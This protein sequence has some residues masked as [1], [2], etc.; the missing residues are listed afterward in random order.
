MPMKNMIQLAVCG[1]VCVCVCVCV[2][3]CVCVCVC[4]CMRAC[5]ACVFMRACA[6]MHMHASTCKGYCPSSKLRAGQHARWRSCGSQRA[7]SSRSPY[8][9][10]TCV[11]DVLFV[12]I[13]CALVSQ[14]CAICLGLAR[15]IHC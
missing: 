7:P 9:G 3:V 8:R 14:A 1:C 5:V 2:R 12:D 6:C 15:T 13:T 10:P 11:C 4:V